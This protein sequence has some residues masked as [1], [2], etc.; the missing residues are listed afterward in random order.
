MTPEPAG[1]FPT[2]IG[3]LG[4]VGD[5][6]RW[7]FSSRADRPLAWLG[8]LDPE[9]VQHRDGGQNCSDGH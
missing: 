9:A 2:R 8:R 7:W 6:P 3:V 4:D 1:L 5:L